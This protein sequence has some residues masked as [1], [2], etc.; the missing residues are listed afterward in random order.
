MDFHFCGWLAGWLRASEDIY[1][2]QWITTICV[3]VKQTTS[4]GQKTEQTKKTK[5]KEKTEWKK[6]THH[7][8]QTERT[9]HARWVVENEA[10]VL[11]RSFWFLVYHFMTPAFWFE[12][13]LNGKR[14]QPCKMPRTVNALWKI[15]RKPIEPYQI[16]RDSL[17]EWHRRAIQL[18]SLSTNL[19]KKCHIHLEQSKWLTSKGFETLNGLCAN[20]IRKKMWT[21]IQS[22]F[23]AW[24]NGKIDE[25]TF[26]TTLIFLPAIFSFGHSRKKNVFHR[27]NGKEIKYKFIFWLYTSIILI[28]IKVA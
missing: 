11:L 24:M 1:V 23:S 9:E 25:F 28:N 22:L 3:Y 21:F 8:K 17:H 19:F 5:E 7:E 26:F 13:H 2:Y 14:L 18:D 27:F 20:G 16:K 4:N 10:N 15:T 12:L 6:R